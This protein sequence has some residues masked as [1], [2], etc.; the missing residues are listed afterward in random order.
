VS[1]MASHIRK[2]NAE[3]ELPLL[4]LALPS[5]LPCRVCI[6]HI[7]ASSN[8]HEPILI[9]MR[10]GKLSGELITLNNVF[11]SELADFLWEI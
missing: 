5:L 8:Q 4:D 9:F 10:P 6:G 3:E 11:L 1:T 2:P 7:E